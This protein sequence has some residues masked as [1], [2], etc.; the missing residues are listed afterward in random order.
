M[1]ILITNDDGIEAKGIAA[2]EQVARLFGARTAWID[3]IQN[4]DAISE[5]GCRAATHADLWL[6]QWPQ[7]AQPGGPQYL[8]EVL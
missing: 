4:V 1:K 2:L 3:S 8:G 5:I 6:T 7:L